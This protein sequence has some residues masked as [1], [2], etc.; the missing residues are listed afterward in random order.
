[1]P[2][3][4]LSSIRLGDPCWR[5]WRR[6]LSPPPLLN[7]TEGEVARY[8]NAIKPLSLAMSFVP[9]S[10]LPQ[11]MGYELFVDAHEAIPTRDG[12]HD[13][14][15]GLCWFLFPHIKHHFN[16]LHTAQIGRL[17]K[18][19]RGRVRDVITVLDENG[20]LIQCPDPLWSCLQAKKW[21]EAFITLRPLWQETKV[22]V[23]G[24]ALL[25]KLVFPY[26][27]M[28]AHAIRVPNNIAFDHD[29]T[30]SIDTFLTKYL[31]RECLQQKPYIPV[32][33]FGIPE[34]HPQQD[35]DFYNNT[36]IFR[37]PI[38]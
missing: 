23:F 9:Q 32:Q 29:H 14:F 27:A 12:L 1:M 11:E 8:L 16:Q 38:E 4:T 6:F 25:E 24:H 37:M 20:F 31:T 15:N 33:I 34:W 2:L 36:R 3:S 19:I 30:S 5:G 18:K 22:M 35:H 28:T 26:T 7:C 10:S 21:T 17:G 13:F